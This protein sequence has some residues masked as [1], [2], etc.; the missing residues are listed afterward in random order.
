MFSL[1]PVTWVV[2]SGVYEDRIKLPSIRGTPGYTF[3]SGKNGYG[4]GNYTLVKTNNSNG[5]GYRIGWDDTGNGTGCA[6][7]YGY[8]R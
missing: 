3:H 6:N 5:N 4:D 2:T 7:N 1:T 8:H